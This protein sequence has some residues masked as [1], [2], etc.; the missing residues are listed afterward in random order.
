MLGR[1]ALSG[2]GSK[3]NSGSGMG[4]AVSGLSPGWWFD[5]PLGNKD[6][7]ASDAKFHAKLVTQGTP[8]SKLDLTC[9]DGFI[10]WILLSDTIP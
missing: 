8:A 1:P 6:P 9:S 2:R 4:E 5:I 3:L 10:C 7:S